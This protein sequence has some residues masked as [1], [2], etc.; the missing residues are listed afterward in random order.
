VNDERIPALSSRW[1]ALC[2]ILPFA[3]ELDMPPL[4]PAK[5]CKICAGSPVLSQRADDNITV[6]RDRWAK[7]LV[8]PPLFMRFRLELCG[9]AWRA[10]CGLFTFHLVV[11]PS[12]ARAD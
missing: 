7:Q 2:G 6:I 1:H 8:P 10:R 3:E 4:L 11:V 5:D 12:C 9:R